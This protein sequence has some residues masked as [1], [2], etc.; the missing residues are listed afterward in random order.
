MA[1]ANQAVSLIFGL[2]RTLEIGSVTFEAFITEEHSKSMKLTELVVEDGSIV[3]DHSIMMPRKLQIKAVKSNTPIFYGG[4]LARALISD[5]SFF[6]N[7]SALEWVTLIEILEERA[8]LKV[9][10]VLEVYPAMVLTDLVTVTDK[11]TSEILQ[12]DMTFQEWRTVNIKE[13]TLNSNNIADDN[14]SNQA[15]GNN[16]KGQKDTTSVESDGTFMHKIFFG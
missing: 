12:V 7:A 5:K 2:N 8:P 15:S 10:T 1:I 11:D 3:N 4:G 6:G 16:T 14:V 9:V 13:E